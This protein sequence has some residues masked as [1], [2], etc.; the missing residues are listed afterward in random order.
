MGIFSSLFGNK[1]VQVERNRQ[2]EFSYFLGENAFG[3]DKNFLEWSLSNPVLM[4]AI[5]IRSKIYSQ[6]EIS[7][8]NKSGEPIE[9]SEVLKLLKNPNW[10]QSQQ[11]FL[12]QQ[13]WFLSATGENYTYKTQRYQS[14]LPTNLYN[15]IPTALDFDEVEQINH[16]I[17][18]KA[19]ADKFAKQKVKYTLDDKEI[20]LELNTL[21]PF[22]DLANNIQVDSWLSSP[23]R[24]KGVK[25]VLENIEE[26]LKAKNVNLKMAQKY[27]ASNKS[28]SEGT[29]MIQEGDRKEIEKRIGNK[30]LLVSNANVDVKHLVSDMKRLYLDEQFSNDANTVLLAFEMNKDILNYAAGGSSTFE[31]QEQG[32]I[33]FVQNSIQSSADNTMN[34]FSESF[35][36][37]EKGESL[38]ASYNHLP[39]MQ[40]VMK[41]KIDTFRAYQETLAIA[42]ENQTI[43]TAEAKTMSDKL[44]NDL[45]L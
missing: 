10:F 31:N 2:G 29:P 28:G 6:M 8:L 25:H 1:S 17:K 14:D 32:I 20:G 38:K 30:S 42:I 9:N 3:Q 23:S 18:N 35:N 36:L 40:V 22:Y 27:L 41:T 37:F 45:G 7:H 11:D 16:F 43:T 15:L 33:R 12:F 21:I 5:A 13:M 44:K 26:N 34:S 4:T 24:V 39:V 19:E